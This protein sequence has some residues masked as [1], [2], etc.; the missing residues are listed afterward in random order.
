[1]P[2]ERTGLV[3]EDEVEHPGDESRYAVIM[4]IGA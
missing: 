2:G 3:S 1:M 4:H